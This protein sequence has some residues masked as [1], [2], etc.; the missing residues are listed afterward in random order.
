M[1]DSFEPIMSAY[2]STGVFCLLTQPNVQQSTEKGLFWWL[3]GTAV[4]D[5]CDVHECTGM[6]VS[7]DRVVSVDCH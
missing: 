6:R 1:V 5:V 2:M 3:S 7:V 4:H